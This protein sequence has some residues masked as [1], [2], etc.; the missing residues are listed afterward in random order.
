VVTPALIKADFG[1][2]AGQGLGQPSSFG[3]PN[4]KDCY[5]VGGDVTFV[6]QATSRADQDLPENAYSY[7]GLPGAEPVQGADRGWAYVFPGQSGGSLT[8]GLILVKGQAGMNFSIMIEGHPYTNATLQTFA[9]HV[10][11]AM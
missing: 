4:A 9:S 8:S 5:Y 10:L 11:A 2:D 7:E 1:A 3:D 6:I